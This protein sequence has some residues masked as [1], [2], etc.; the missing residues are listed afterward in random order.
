ML[1]LVY[2]AKN[3]MHNL[4]PALQVVLLLLAGGR[5]LSFEL[6]AVSSFRMWNKHVNWPF[7]SDPLCSLLARR[8]PYLGQNSCLAHTAA[9]VTLE[10]K[11]F[12]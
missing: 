12:F 7:L 3:E 11:L 4:I 6:D 8:H 1:T 5:H 10:V 9:S 2:F